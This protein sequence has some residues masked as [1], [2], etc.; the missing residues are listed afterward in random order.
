MLAHELRN[1]L[2]PIRTGLDLLEMEGVDDETVRWTRTMLKRQVEHMAR[3]VDDLLDVSRIMRGKIQLRKERIDL[4]T[5]LERSIETARPIIDAQDHELIVALPSS[6]VWIEGD[7]VRLSQVVGNLLNNAAKYNDKAGHIWLTAAREQ[8]E[9]VIRVRDD[10]VGIAPEAMPHIFELFM[11]VDQSIERSQGGL[12]IGL[13]LAR[14]LVQM[15][16]GTI[17]SHS[18]GR[19][20]GS[21]FVV[22]LP[23]HAAPAG[24]T[25]KTAGPPAEKAADV[26]PA[27]R[28]I[29]VV[30]D[31]ADA[32]RTLAELARRWNYDVRIARDGAAALEL[33]GEYHPDVVL[34][35][36]GLP[37]MSGYQVATRLRQQPDF[38]K[39]L[40]V[41]MTGYG[42]DEDR[43]RSREAGFNLHLVKPVPPDVLQNLL[44]QPNLAG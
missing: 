23:V 2:A 22:R 29:L 10:G 28:R 32:A 7:S 17:Q 8:D 44:A 30:D 20:L 24:E 36:I 26:K 31:N 4:A 12:G 43:R 6:P 14:N 9:A 25:D 16:G 35:D 5:V 11:Q 33:A 41:A 15:H 3:L 21:E 13:T 42:Q 40:L 1:P 19:G 18:A 27:Q 38:Q 39:T 34:L 37:K